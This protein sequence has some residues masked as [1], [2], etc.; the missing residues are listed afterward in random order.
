M[1]KIFLLILFYATAVHSAARTTKEKKC[2]AHFEAS[3]VFV[4]THEIKS[5]RVWN[6]YLGL[7]RDRIVDTIDLQNRFR[8]MAKGIFRGTR[9]GMSLDYELGWYEL[10]P[11]KENSKILLANHPLGYASYR[12]EFQEIVL[13]AIN[14]VIENYRLRRNWSDQFLKK[15]YE[16]AILDSGR[17]LYFVFEAPDYGT[18][19]WKIQGTLKIIKD[20]ISQNKN[21]PIETTLSIK[22]PYNNG[23]K[24]EIGNFAISKDFNKEAFVELLTHLMLHAKKLTVEPGHQANKFVYYTYADALSA[25]MYSSLGFKPIPDH[26]KPIEKY[27]TKWV[28]YGI[29]AEGILQIPVFMQT[30]RSYWDSVGLTDILKLVPE[31]HEVEKLFKSIEKTYFFLNPGQLSFSE[32]FGS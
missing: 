21:L 22:L 23:V 20:L 29:S 9:D 19:N 25:R 18:T 4:G 30:T 7:G 2:S 13:T 5:A 28:P 32:G 1:F 3:T 24:F 15:L 16:D 17:S 10:L 6:R 27:G 12:Y 26:E 8:K 11:L 14:F 31:L